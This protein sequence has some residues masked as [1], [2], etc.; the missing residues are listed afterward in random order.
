[1]TRSIGIIAGALICLCCCIAYAEYGVID[2][3]TWPKSWP[4]Q[5]EPLRKQARTLKGP[6]APNLHYAIHFN[7]RKEFEAAWRHI[8]KV[9]T[10]GAPVFIKSAPNFFLGDFK[11]GVVIHCPPA[12][13]DPAPSEAPIPG[14][15]NPRE[16]WMNAT[17]ID[18][19][20]D[21]DI[22]RFNRKSVP[23]G[24]PV[25]DERSKATRPKD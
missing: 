10:K 16:R 14:L 15:A 1:M 8:L 22:I 11:A 25:I 12:R 9:K 21:D 2:K 4:A 23:A 24:T 17:F 20:V 18:L 3:G 5:L 19:V 13:Q 7:N 6:M